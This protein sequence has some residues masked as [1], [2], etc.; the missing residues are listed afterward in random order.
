MATPPEPP[1]DY[2]AEED[3][4]RPVGPPPP[5][6]N[7]WIWLVLL[8]VVVVGGLLAW[9]FLTRG[10]DKTTVPDVIGLQET[11]ATQRLELVKKV[12]LAHCHSIARL[13]SSAVV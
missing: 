8:L 6:R 10:N 7:W 3:V 11:A 13:S 2:V 1:P 9:F 4:A 12:Y 5:E